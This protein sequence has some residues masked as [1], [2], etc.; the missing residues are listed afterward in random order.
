MGEIELLAAHPQMS[1]GEL[2]QGQNCAPPG[3]LSTSRQDIPDHSLHQTLLK[4]QSDLPC[5]ALYDLGNLSLFQSCGDVH[6][7][8]LNPFEESRR[9]LFGQAA[10]EVVSHDEHQSQGQIGLQQRVELAEELC[11]IGSRGCGEEFSELVQYEHQ[12]GLLRIP[13]QPASCRLDQPAFSPG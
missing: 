8:P 2:Q 12:P 13:L 10:E 6:K 7:A 9:C 1:Q 4:L 11:G 3:P 5:R